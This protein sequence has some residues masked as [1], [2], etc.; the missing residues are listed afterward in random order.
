MHSAHGTISR[1]EAVGA[2]TGGNKH[3]MILDHPIHP[4]NTLHRKSLQPLIKKDVKDV[5][6]V[7]LVL[8]KYC[9]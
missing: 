6:G 7:V 2:A 1:Q 8:F 9:F 4:S 5:K 3:K